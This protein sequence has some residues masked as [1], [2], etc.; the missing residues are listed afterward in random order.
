MYT[1]KE[2][3]SSFKLLLM[4]FHTIASQTVS[5]QVLKTNL[6]IHFHKNFHSTTHRSLRVKELPNAVPQLVEEHGV[7]GGVELQPQQVFDVSANME[8]DPV[9]ATNQQGQQPVQEAADRCLT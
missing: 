8:A 9:V 1:H 3:D 2:S 5:F 4:Y 7:E 6:N